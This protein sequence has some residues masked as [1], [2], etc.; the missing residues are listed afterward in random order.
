MGKSDKR[1]LDNIEKYGCHVLSVLEDEDSPT[2]TYSI[3][4]YETQSKP[5]LLIVG[6]DSKISQSMVNEYCQRLKAGESFEVGRYYSGFLEG[7]DVCFIEM[8]KKYHDVYPLACNTHY[9]A[10]PYTVYQL[11]WPTTSEQWPWDVGTSDF[12]QWSQPILNRT[13]VL[14]K[15]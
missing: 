2:F 4:I 5:E 12:Y 8:D 6:L 3:G 15:I 1:I 13:G 11:V 14:E 10:L 7:F 9:G